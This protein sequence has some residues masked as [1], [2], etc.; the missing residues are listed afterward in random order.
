MEKVRI[1]DD[2]FNYVNGEWISKAKI[3]SDM[4]VTGGF[5]DLSKKVEKIM[6]KE[7]KSLSNKPS[8]D[9]LLNR[10]G[11]LYTKVIDEDNRALGLNNLLDNY[12]YLDNIVDKDSFDSS[13]YYLY[14][15]RYPLP[16]NFEITMDMKNANKYALYLINPNT[17]LPD[18]TMYNTPMVEQL[19][20]VYTTMVRQIF[21]MLNLDNVDTILEDTLSFDKKLSK[22]VKSRE[23]LADYIKCYNPYDIADVSSKLDFDLSSF[24]KARFGKLPNNIIVFDT[25]FIEGYI[26]L[27]KDSYKEYASWAKV[28]YLLNN[29]A[30]ISEDLRNVSGIYSRALNGTKEMS[31]INR[32]AYYLTNN[33]YGEVLGIHYGRKYFGEAAKE[34]VINIVKNLIESYKSRLSNNTWLSKETIAK[35]IV[36][37][38]SMK[39]KIGY[40]DKVSNIYY[41][42]A[43]NP[44]DTLIE[45]IATLNKINKRYLDSLLF[46]AVD[47]EEWAMPGNMVNACYNPSCNDITFPA[48]ILQKPFYEYGD[49][50]EHNYG[51]IGCV[52]GHEISHA[53]DNNGAQM[54]E[55]GNINNW[56]SEEDYENFKAKTEAMVEQFD[57]LPLAGAKV[58][59]RLSVSE[60]I[61]DNGGLAS[62]ITS[63]KRIKE[64]PDFSEFFINY[65]RIWCQKARPEYIQ[66]LL[67]VDVHGPSYYRTN[68]QVRNF[69]EF[70]EAFDVKETDKLYLSPDKRI[71]IW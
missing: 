54:D 46:K 49:T 12:H 39:I 22:I 13:Y 47:K 58:N 17:I 7:L 24:I 4:P 16:F 10:A 37:L 57:G 44:E 30:Y 32:Y 42:L 8:K 40:P 62:S 65:A 9:E 55:F 41:H 29:V 56:W 25:K 71:S 38:E 21:T 27:I 31:K 15:N 68:Q 66:L 61:A 70:H 5:V 3:P 59:G 43:F 23:E 14:D 34:D 6:L 45:I 53:F 2:L 19:F 67:T 36:K 1:Q 20:S 52:I 69:E 26:S 33:I 60:N 11:I 35:A 63:L 48:A 50:L 18:T 28:N 51:G 64:N